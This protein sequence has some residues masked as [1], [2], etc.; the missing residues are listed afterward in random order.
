MHCV[1]AAHSVSCVKHT[2]YTAA[3]CM[4]QFA[5][6]PCVQQ[7]QT[8]TDSG[9]GCG[10]FSCNCSSPGR[11]RGIPCSCYCEYFDACFVGIFGETRIEDVLGGVRCPQGLFGGDRNVVLSRL[12]SRSRFFN[13]CADKIWLVRLLS[14][15]A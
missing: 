1:Y 5:A 13:S 7:S 6:S 14:K 11:R 2:V 15:L 8:R 12:T 10:C 4:L 9:W 3:Y